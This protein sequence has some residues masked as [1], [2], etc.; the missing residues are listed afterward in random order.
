MPWLSVDLNQHKFQPGVQAVGTGW[1]QTQPVTESKIN[2]WP[3]Q[4]AH[5]VALLSLYSTPHDLLNALK[6]TLIT[7][8][9]IRETDKLKF[10][11]KK[12][13]LKTQHFINPGCCCKSYYKLVLTLSSF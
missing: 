6:P 9:F 7:Q 11:K 12:K 1:C 3:E 13:H 4:T 5:S 2:T 8:P 10:D